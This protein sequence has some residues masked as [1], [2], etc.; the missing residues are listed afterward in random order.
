MSNQD[1]KILFEDYGIEFTEDDV[2]DVDLDVLKKY[3]EKI[4]NI[5]RRLENE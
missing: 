4:N 5:I 1:D 3:R 2:K